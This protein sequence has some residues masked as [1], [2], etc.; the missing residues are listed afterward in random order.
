MDENDV[1]SR[2][3]NRLLGEFDRMFRRDSEMA[4]ENARGRGVAEGVHAEE[5]SRV[6]EILP[7]AHF[8]AEFDAHARLHGRRQDGIAIFLRLRLP[9][10]GL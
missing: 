4:H 10:V 8:D 5:P 2:G 1:L 6:A 7:P 3:G 9:L